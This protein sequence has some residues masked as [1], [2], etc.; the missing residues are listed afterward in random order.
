MAL[1]PIEE[2]PRRRPGWVTGVW[3][4]Y[5]RRRVIYYTLQAISY[6]RHIRQL[7]PWQWWRI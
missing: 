6:H 2:S 4:P 5:R 3:L 7:C 1:Q